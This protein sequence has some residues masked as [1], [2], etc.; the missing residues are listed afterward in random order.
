MRLRAVVLSALCVVLAAPAAA[1]ADVV[2]A[3]EVSARLNGIPQN[4]RVLGNPNAPVTIELFHDLKCP[5]CRAFDLKVMPAIIHQYVKGGR[6]RIIAQPQAFI[7]PDGTGDD[8]RAASMAVALSMQNKFWNFF[9]L[10]YL[11]Q[12]DETTDYATD[13]YLLGLAAAIPGADG[14]R[15]L[16]D[17]ANPKV[18]ASLKKSSAMMARFRVFG[19]PSVF[20]G[21]TGQGFEYQWQNSLK[22][23]AR[24]IRRDLR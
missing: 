15:A 17:R 22:S 7:D 5:F 9:D 16:G 2:G 12:Q 13:D 1:H 11:N 6:V 10:F 4:G 24:L 20:V 14:P 18:A 21:R 19:V 3:N 8:R 23:I